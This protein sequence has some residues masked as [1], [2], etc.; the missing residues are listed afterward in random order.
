MRFYSFGVKAATL[1]AALLLAA[2]CE[3]AQQ[4][5][6]GTAGQGATQTTTG[7][8][9]RVQQATAPSIRPGSQEDLVQSIGDRVFFDFDRS[10]LRPDARRTVERWAGWLKQYPAVTVT[11]EGH[12]DERG[13]REYNLA[14]GERRATAVRQY[15]AALGVDTAR[16]RTVSYGKERPVCGTHSE[17][18]WSQ[19]RRG[20]MQVN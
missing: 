20:T 2:A 15:L 5:S 11:V 8:Q 4:D 13:T 1:T 18:C 6:A 17:D 3:T 7:S 14:L 16:L 10:D 19:N 12:A 9:P